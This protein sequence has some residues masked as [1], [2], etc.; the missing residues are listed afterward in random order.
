MASDRDVYLFVVQ[1]V[2]SVARASVVLR[3]N[4]W[5]PSVAPSSSKASA[6]SPPDAG[7][8]KMLVAV[9][10]SK[11]DVLRECH[12]HLCTKAGRVR[13]L[14]ACG[15]L[16]RN[17][18]VI[19]VVCASQVL[20]ASQLLMLYNPTIVGWNGITSICGPFPFIKLRLASSL[21]ILA[22]WLAAADCGW[23]LRMFVDLLD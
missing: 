4:F 16:T 21:R 18:Y 17:T 1:S 5:K 14:V 6:A 15:V 22:L 8:A 13:Q 10:T 20:C 3:R 11:D 23:K 7:P 9:G 12:R 2:A 19:L